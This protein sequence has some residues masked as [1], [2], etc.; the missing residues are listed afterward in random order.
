MANRKQEI[1]EFLIHNLGEHPRDIVRFSSEHFGV[2]RQLVNR[3]LHELVQEKKI[4]ASGKTRK[5]YALATEEIAFSY[6][7]TPGLQEDK[8][9]RDD[10]APLLNNVPP[11]VREISQYG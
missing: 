4:T 11:N 10:I 2:S 1:K 8:V 9:W 7:I 3:Y 6:E 5:Q